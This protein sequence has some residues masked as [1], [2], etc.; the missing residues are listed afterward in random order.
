MLL[1][2]VVQLLLIGIGS[3]ALY[4]M[5]KGITQKLDPVTVAIGLVAATQLNITFTR[6]RYGA[7][8]VQYAPA[9]DWTM[10]NFLGAACLVYL[11]VA[12]VKTSRRIQ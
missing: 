8:V 6:I 3:V 2:M 12:L 11:A 7:T 9:P 5:V 4:R 10:S 1:I